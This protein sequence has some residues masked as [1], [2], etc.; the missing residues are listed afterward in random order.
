MIMQVMQ[1]QTWPAPGCALTAGQYKMVLQT[2]GSSS[3]S[4]TLT[5]L[6]QVFCLSTVCLEEGPGPPFG[7]KF[8]IKC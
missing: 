2:I 7:P 6:Y 4:L 3:A 8:T 5:T 1:R